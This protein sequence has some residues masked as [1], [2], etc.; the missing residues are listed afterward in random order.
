MTKRQDFEAAKTRYEQCARML[1]AHEILWNDMWEAQP[2]PFIKIKDY[3]S[4]KQ[5]AMRAL[6]I[7]PWIE[8]RKEYEAASKALRGQS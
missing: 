1:R 7:N 3:T 8:A 4:N 2:N 5:R 6:V